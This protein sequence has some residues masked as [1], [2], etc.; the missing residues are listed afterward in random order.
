VASPRWVAGGMVALSNAD[1]ASRINTERIIA[2]LR[3]TDVDATVMAA[4]T[5]F[6]SG[7]N[8]LEVTLT[9][10]G[11]LEAI[12]Q[13]S[14]FAPMGAL[15]GAGTVLSEQQVDQSL[16][17]GAQFI[18]TPSISA[19]VKYALKSDIGTLP[20]VFSP[21]EIQS[22]L[23]G[24]AAA[25]KLFPASSVGAGYL[26]AVL[27]PFPSARIIPVGGMTLESIPKYLGAGAFAIGVGGPLVGD[28]ASLGGDL[29]GLAARAAEFLKLVQR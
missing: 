18:V 17:V 21:T 23:E 4:K 10:E 20:G 22:A 7:I 3:G 25:V 12:N 27:D 1:L 6:D 19:S 8:I 2:I 5:L 16:N 15:V 11:A 28:A 24:G 26:K 29:E 13:I 14:S 9:L